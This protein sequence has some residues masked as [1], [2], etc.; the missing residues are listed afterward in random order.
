MDG[1]E[2][3]VHSSQEMMMMVVILGFIRVSARVRGGSL[4][5]K[6]LL[7]MYI[8]TYAIYTMQV[9]VRIRE[10]DVLYTHTYIPRETVSS[11]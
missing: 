3:R 11:N 10:G 1:M 2:F 7:H 8:H 9:V 4:I 6:H 5:R